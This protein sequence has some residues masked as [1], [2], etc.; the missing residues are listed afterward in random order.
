MVIWMSQG[1]A[2]GD[3]AGVAAARALSGECN[4]AGAC[5]DCAFTAVCGPDGAQG[6]SVTKTCS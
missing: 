3:G 2:L 5:K 4:G 6:Q 1:L